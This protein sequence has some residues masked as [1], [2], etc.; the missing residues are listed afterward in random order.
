MNADDLTTVAAVIRLLILWPAGQR[1]GLPYT[2]TALFA[3]QK[4]GSSPL[5]S[6]TPMEQ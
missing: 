6:N 4:P 3:R 1:G 2:A 5:F